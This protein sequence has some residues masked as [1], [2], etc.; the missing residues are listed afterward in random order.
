MQSE[1]GGRQR[2]RFSRKRRSTESGGIIFGSKGL[3][4]TREPTVELTVEQPTSPIEFLRVGRLLLLYS[5]P[6]PAPNNYYILPSH[7]ISKIVF[8]IL[9]ADKLILFIKDIFRCSNLG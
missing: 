7:P 5:G 8:Q 9:A 1:T 4:L 2:A 6:T 3:Q